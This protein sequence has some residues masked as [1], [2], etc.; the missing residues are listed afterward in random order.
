MTA[1]AGRMS[2]RL[3]TRVF[4][5]ASSQVVLAGRREA[6]AARMLVKHVLLTLADDKARPA[7]RFEARRELDETSTR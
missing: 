4:V 7:E 2:R 6:F 3:P 5:D 1:E